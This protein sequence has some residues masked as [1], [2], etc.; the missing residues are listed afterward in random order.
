[1]K[2][3]HLEV[4]AATGA[5]LLIKDGQT[6]TRVKSAKEEREPGEYVQF[7][8]PSNTPPAQLAAVRRMGAAP[9]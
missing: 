9:F 8:A 7:V 5:R 6:F 4:Y 3:W 2:G 1:M